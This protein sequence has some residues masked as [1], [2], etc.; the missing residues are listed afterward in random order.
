M[1]PDFNLHYDRL[2]ENDPTKPADGGEGSEETT[3][4]DTPGHVRNLCLVWL[5][6]RQQFLNY[7]YLVGGTFM[8]GEEMNEITLNFSAHI[9]TLKGHGLDALFVALL[10]QLPRQIVQAEMRYSTQEY[11]VITLIA[12]KAAV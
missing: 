2:R 11:G 12:V 9:V 5:D 10:D 8:P 1:S 7:A 3:Y 6:G 4:Y